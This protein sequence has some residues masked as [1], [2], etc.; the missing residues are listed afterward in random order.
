MGIGTDGDYSP[1]EYAAIDSAGKIVIGEAGVQ[2]G[3]IT[4]ETFESP[5]ASATIEVNTTGQV[6]LDNTGG[7]AFTIDGAGKA[8]NDIY[9]W[10]SSVKISNNIINFA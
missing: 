5:V 3:D 10:N 9:L 6:I 1:V 4:F 7:N 2:T 8:F